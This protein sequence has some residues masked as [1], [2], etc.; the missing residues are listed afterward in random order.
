MNTR[1]CSRCD[2]VAVIRTP[3][4][5]E[6]LCE[7]HFLASVERRVK[8]RIRQDNLFT[9]DET[10]W[11]LGL[12]GGKDSAV[13]ATILAET[14]DK[15]PKVVLKGACIHEGIEGYR[16]QSLAAAR[17]LAEELDIPLETRSYDELYDLRMDE[18]AELD[19]LDM[20][21][22]AYCGVFRRDILERLASEFNADV[23]LV[24][25]N[26]DDEA[27]TAMM[28][29]L[30]GDL[31]Q[32]AKHYD[33]SLAPLDERK[34]APFVPRAKPLRDIP[35]KEVAMYA[36]LRDLPAHMATCPHAEASFRGEIQ[37]VIH[38]LE[39]AHPGTRHS[40]IAGYEEF[41][42]LLAEARDGDDRV[43]Q[44]CSTC[45]RPTTSEQCRACQLRETLVS[46]KESE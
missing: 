46:A 21:P 19:P 18:V 26:L 45:S 3:Y 4:A 1:P 38:D 5:G 12:S 13:M 42:S 40:I 20:A 24:G 37:S 14:F 25:H 33:A 15:N 11:L 35:E 17:E 39:S 29:V 23:L 32:M 31:F 16:D 28:N 27:Q 22:C 36:H 30:E 43:L 6:H 7:S 9:G 41:A 34:D 44:S 2:E 10:T 8:R